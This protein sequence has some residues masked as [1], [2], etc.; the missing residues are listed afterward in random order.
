MYTDQTGKFPKISSRRN[1][2]IMVLVELDSN[3]ILIEPMK[4]RTPGEMIRAYQALFDR[5]KE[6]G[7]KPKQHLLDNKWS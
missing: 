3:A 7:I 1:H 4:N 2:Y 5:L 6:C